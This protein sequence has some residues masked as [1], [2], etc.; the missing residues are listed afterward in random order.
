MT[1]R[2]ARWARRHRGWAR[3]LALAVVWVAL[4]GAVV[5]DRVAVE[6]GR[7]LEEYTSGDYEM[8][9]RR[10]RN[11]QVEKPDSSPLHF[12]VGD[13]L[14][15]LGRFDE[16]AAEFEQALQGGDAPLRSSML[17]NMGNVCYQKQQYAQAVDAY[18]Q[19]LRLDAG[20][21]DT[22]VNLELA[23]ERLQQQ[24]QAQQ[25]G[26]DG[27]PLDGQSAPEGDRQQQGS[28]QQQP[29]ARDQQQGNDQQPSGPQDQ[30]Q[31]TGQQAAD[32]SQQ[33]QAQQ[34]EGRDG[35]RRM[36]REEAEQLLR[37]LQDRDRAARM[38]RLHAA[39]VSQGKDW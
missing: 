38:R 3:L 35:E 28:E 24:E 9:L 30:Q 7:A 21:R 12:N 23:L 13:A 27:E 19:A 1:H 26:D 29:G 4:T 16:A 10:Y 2:E 22:K 31:G 33:E 36:S 18:S 5:G 37:A 6:A 8:A 20:D 34:G 25:Q 39:G 11:A 14:Y 32:Q 15:K 17:H